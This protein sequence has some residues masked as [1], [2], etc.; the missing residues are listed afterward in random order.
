MHF[1]SISGK[2]EKKFMISVFYDFEIPLNGSLKRKSQ[3]PQSLNLRIRNPFD[4]SA[5]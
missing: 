5:P 2:L 3:I 1:L 4:G